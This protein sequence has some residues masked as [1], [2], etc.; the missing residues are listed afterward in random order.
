M[1][2]TLGTGMDIVCRAGT[3]VTTSIIGRR[4]E[5]P[6]TDVRGSVD[7]GERCRADLRYL[8]GLSALIGRFE[9]AVDRWDDQLPAS[10]SDH[11][12]ASQGV[13]RG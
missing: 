2:E 3:G 9:H 4:A 12:L 5:M 7:S 8:G 1:L 13:Q 11:S 6:L 10:Q